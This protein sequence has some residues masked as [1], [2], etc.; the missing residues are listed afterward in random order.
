MV[1]TRCKFQVLLPAIATLYIPI[2]LTV[3]FPYTVL[4]SP[5]WC[6]IIATL[7]S[8]TVLIETCFSGKHLYSFIGLHIN[9]ISFNS[10]H[11]RSTV[12]ACVR[13]DHHRSCCLQKQKFAIL[14]YFSDDAS[15][16]GSS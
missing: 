15:C 11:T 5:S 1:S 12:G 10:T 6:A 16:N 14:V 9:R 7:V 8:Y 4:V 3:A 13:Q 2:A